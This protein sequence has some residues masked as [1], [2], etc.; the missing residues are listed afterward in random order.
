MVIGL[1]IG[2]FNVMGEY[3]DKQAEAKRKATQLTV[4]RGEA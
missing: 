3:Q 2:M 4:Q 1:L